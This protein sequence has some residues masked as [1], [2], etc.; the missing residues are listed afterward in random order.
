MTAWGAGAAAGSA[1]RPGTMLGFDD[2]DAGF[3]AHHEIVRRAHRRYRGARIG[4]GGA[5]VETLVATVL[6]QKVTSEEAHRSWAALV[7]RYGDDAPGSGWRPPR[8]RIPTCSPSSATRR[9]TRSASNG[10]GPRRSAGCAPAP[11]AFAPWRHESPAEARRVLEHFPGRRSLDLRHGHVAQPGRS[12][13]GGHRRLPLPAHRQLHAHRPPSGQRR[14]DA[15]PAGALPGPA[16]AVRCDCCCSAV[17]TRRAEPRGP[18]CASSILERD[19]V[20]RDVH[21]RARRLRSRS[22]GPHRPRWRSSPR[23][24][25][26]G[27]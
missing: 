23:Q 1:R 20:R 27:P 7:W 8:A 26:H 15:R 4:C 3:V 21:L 14:R 24:V 25:S 9:G 10:A 18:G 6:E 19:R 12:R 17:R 11:L 2:D 13:R 22:R 16:R 5:L